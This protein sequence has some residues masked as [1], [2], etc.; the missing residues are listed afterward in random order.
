MILSGANHVFVFDLLVIHFRTVGDD[1]IDTQIYY[2]SH[3]AGLVNGP[4]I[5]SM[6]L[7]LESGYIASGK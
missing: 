7:I 2:P 6:V 5:Y 3:M 4:G 1:S